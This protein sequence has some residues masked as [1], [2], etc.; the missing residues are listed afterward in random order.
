MEIQRLLGS[1][2]QMVLDECPG[3]WRQRGRDRKISGAFDAL[4]G[5][6]QNPHLASNLV[7]PV[8]ASSKA[9][10]SRYLRARSAE[11]LQEIGFDGYAVGGL[12]VGEGQAAMFET[13]DATIPHLPNRIDRVT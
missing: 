1:D 5:A 8:S 11:Q 9:G 13:L 10:S 4:G 2:I 12:A 3:L 7:G 6:I